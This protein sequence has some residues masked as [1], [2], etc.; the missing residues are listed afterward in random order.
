MLQNS[1]ALSIS[2]SLSEG[3][4]VGASP[5]GRKVAA[6]CKPQRIAVFRALQLGDLLC[7]V[8]ALRALRTACPTSEITIIGLP[9]ARAFVERFPH[10]LDRFIEF[11][12]FPGLPE[13]PWN[14]LRLLRFLAVVRSKKIDLVLQ[15][16]GCGP[17]VNPLTA[18]FGGRQTAGFF[19][20]ET[21]R[22][23]SEG[24]MPFPA[25]E[26]E[27]RQH[28]RLM[29]FLG[30]PARGDALEF[31]LFD[32]DREEFRALCRR[33]GLQPGNYVCIHPGAQ[34]ASRRWPVQRFAAVADALAAW[35]LQIVLTGI[36]S[37]KPLTGAVARHMHAP[38]IDLAGRTSL[39]GVAAVIA[40]AR[41]LIANDT[42][43]SHLAA[44]LKT[45]SVIIASGSDPGRWAPLNRNL[46]R[47]LYHQVSCRPCSFHE[48]PVGHP[49]A[50]G[51]S[52]E[53]VQ[54]AVTRLTAL[55]AARAS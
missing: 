21:Q 29:E 45:P 16:H 39:G 43:V 5:Q 46:H 32:R 18:W 15:M 25:H 47:V 31:P 26:P 30:F 10:Y 24:F 27:I 11:P 35:N 1:S 42:G 49:C 55:N 36:E 6:R 37:E 14:A 9:W 2:L 28:I 8:P 17:I 50:W 53:A 52:V 13:Q 23:P 12:G 7:V 48:C 54:Q 38:A 51:V 33:T 22:P 3:L 20:P 44:A 40:N 4:G 19:L 34:L 41:L